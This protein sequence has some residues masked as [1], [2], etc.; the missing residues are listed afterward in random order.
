MLSKGTITDTMISGPEVRVLCLGNRTM[1]KYGIKI[2]KLKRKVKDAILPMLITICQ[3][4]DQTALLYG[5]QY[6]LFTPVCF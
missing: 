4:Y 3:V 2:A 1:R 5:K 6:Q